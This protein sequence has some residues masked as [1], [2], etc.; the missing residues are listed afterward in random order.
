MSETFWVALLVWCSVWGR[1]GIEYK[2][3]GVAVQAD[4]ETIVP[5]LELD[6]DIFSLLTWIC[7]ITH[8][9]THEEIP[10]HRELLKQ[11]DYMSFPRDVMNKARQSRYI[12]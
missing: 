5:C 2:I 1:G 6:A 9:H 4:E 7:N 8:T 12:R 11:S 10:T 3:R